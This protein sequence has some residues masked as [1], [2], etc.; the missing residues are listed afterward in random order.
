LIA[1]NL[2]KT[3]ID[4]INCIEE[5]KYT[6]DQLISREIDEIMKRIQSIKE[7]E[8]GVEDERTSAEFFLKLSIQ[9]LIIVV[10][11]AICINK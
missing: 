2:K 10:T 7:K 4:D 9:D 8:Q 11:V 3:S 6:K 5:I 1:N